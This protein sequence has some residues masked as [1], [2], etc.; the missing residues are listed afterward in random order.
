MSRPLRGL[1][2]AVVWLYAL[3]LVVPLYY[4][5]ASTFK[6]NR[7]IFTAPFALPDGEI[8]ILASGGRRTTEGIG[9]QNFRRAIDIVFLDDALTNSFLITAGALLSTLALAIPASYAL[10]RST[11]RIARAMERYFSAG[12]LIPGFAALVPTV[13]LAIELDMFQTKRFLVLVYP[14][15]AL[16][17]SVILLTQFMRTIPKELEESAC[18]DGANQFRILRSIYLPIAKPGIA[19]VTILNFLGFWNEYLYALVI[20]GI[21]PNVRTVQVAIPGLVQEGST[22]FGVLAAG[23]VL[24]LLPVYLLYVILQRRMETALTE[25]AVKG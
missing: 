16:P 18:V 12:L 6:D 22:Q 2:H 7:Q 8:E 20:G 23:T 21:N 9:F 25:G 10:A 11:G 5:V 24:S 13:L 14:A 19:A 17:L 1:S 4:L 3:L 15:G